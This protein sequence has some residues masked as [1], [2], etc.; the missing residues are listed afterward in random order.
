MGERGKSIVEE[1]FACERQLANTLGL[2][3]ELLD[4]KSRINVAEARASGS[5]S[6]DRESCP[7]SRSGF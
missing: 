1:K 5:A 4:A 7:P 3:S 2:Y 6:I